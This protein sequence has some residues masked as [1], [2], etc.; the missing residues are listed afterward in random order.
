MSETGVCLSVREFPLAD[1]IALV[2]HSEMA[3]QQVTSYFAKATK[4]F[5]FSLKN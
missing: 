4:H 5:E 3:L 2:V 1:D